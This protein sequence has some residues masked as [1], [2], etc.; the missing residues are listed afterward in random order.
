M[1]EMAYDPDFRAVP[2]SEKIIYIPDNVVNSM[3]TDSQMC[4]KLV[5]AVKTG[6]LPNAM[7]EMHCGPL[8]HDR[9]LTT[10][11]RILFLW[12]RKHVLTGKNLKTLE[13]LV[14]FCLD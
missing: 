14:R 6:H 11:Q 8:R 10:A 3:S 5:A 7:Q 2:G 9:W 1:N 4:Y 12:T 13:L